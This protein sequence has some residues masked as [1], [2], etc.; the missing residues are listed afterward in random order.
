MS[1]SE[2]YYACRNGDAAKVK[3][4]LSTMFTTD[5]DRIEPNGSTA[6]HA[7]AYF[8]HTDIV[9]LLLDKDASRN[10]K[11]KYGKTPE[12]EA[13]TPEIAQLFQDVKAEPNVDWIISNVFN[14]TSYHRR[15]YSFNQGS[16][17][18]SYV[19]N[20]LFDADELWNGDEE[21]VRYMNKIKEVFKEAIENNN[22]GML[23]HAYTMNSPFYSV[24]NKTLA[25]HDKLT[26]V[27]RENPP[28]FCAFARFLA[29]D[30]P[31]LRPYRFTGIT[32]RG[33][34]ISKE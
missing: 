17:T 27:E 9:R 34:A 23:I 10:Q 7:A 8:G 5:I 4:L 21:H 26:D 24:L 32:Y 33:V 14:A 28:W 18:L 15:F 19:I 22:G 11:N 6:L 13:K 31:T 29:S 30:E 16:P 2:F 1:V 25:S 12:E 3:T 20:K